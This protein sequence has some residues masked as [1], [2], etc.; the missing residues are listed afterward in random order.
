MIPLC[1]GA[2]L[3]LALGQES[4]RL[5]SCP[6]ASRARASVRPGARRRQRH[7]DG[8]PPRRSSRRRR[9]SDAARPRR[10]RRGRAAAGRRSVL[11]GLDDAADGTGRGCSRWS[12]HA[13]VLDRLH[14]GGRHAHALREIGE[15]RVDGRVLLQPAERDTHQNCSRTR[16][17]FSQSRRCP[18]GCG[19]A[20]RPARGRS[21][22]EAAPLVGV[23]ADV[24]EH[25]R[26]DHA[27]AAHLQPAR[28]TCTSGSRAAADAA[29]HVRLD[30]RLG[31]REVVRAEA[32]APLL[33]VERAHH[34]HAACPLRSGERQPLVDGEPLELVEDRGSASRR[35]CR[36]GSS[37]RSRPCRAAGDAP[38][39]RGSRRRGLRAQDVAVQE[40][41]RTR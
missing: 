13:P 12:G 9:R 40:E 32:D 2:E 41:R 14:L 25:G 27:G 36:A 10:R 39:A 34:V 23:D 17:S 4:C 6:G 30:R 20:G 38:L 22:I 21:R 31:E 5:K 11:A 15:G 35:S 26:V 16:R 8:G 19:A 7:G 29:R 28:S 3:E 24:G 1:S 18:A 33:P 37:G